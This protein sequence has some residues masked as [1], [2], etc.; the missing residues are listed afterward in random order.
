MTLPPEPINELLQQAQAVVLASVS[1]VRNPDGSWQGDVTQVVTAQPETPRRGNMPPAIGALQPRVAQQV[2]LEVER[3][4]AGALAG[5][6]EVVRPVADYVLMP[7]QRGPFFLRETAAGTP[8]IIG[9]L[10]PDTYGLD[11]VE[12]A[13]LA[14]KG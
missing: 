8:E 3:C 13:I 5:E 12:A 9:R 7:G 10:G 4:L 14:S 6:V 11:E 2:R 1:A